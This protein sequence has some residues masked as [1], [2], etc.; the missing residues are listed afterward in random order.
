MKRRGGLADRQRRLRFRAAA[1]LALALACVALL[2]DRN[3][4]WLILAAAAGL[5]ALALVLRFPRM[6]GRQPDKRY[7]AFVAGRAAVLA[8]L[9]MLLGSLAVAHSGEKHARHI[10]LCEGQRVQLGDWELRLTRIVP[11]AGEGFTAIQADMAASRKAAPALTLS[12]RLLHRFASGPRGDGSSR[13]R[14][15][16]GDLALGLTG[17]GSAS[18][19]IALDAAWRPLAVW[20]VV[21][22]WL[23]ALG[24]LGMALMAW[25]SIAWRERA[26]GRIAMRREDQPLPGRPLAAAHAPPGRLLP[27][28]AIGLALVL[29]ALLAWP[30]TAAVPHPVYPGGAALIKARQSLIEGPPNTNRWIVIADA[31]ARRGRYADAAEILLGAVEASPQASEGWLALGDALYAHAGGVLTPA[32]ALAYER[33]DRAGLASFAARPLAAEAMERSAR[34]ALARAW[35][36]RGAPAILPGKQP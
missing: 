17:L 28:L 1:L 23:A 30:R 15:L 6:P 35:R 33:A 11:V 26:A 27:V 2:L 10:T 9:A 31:M 16:M 36:A 19:C 32:A 29:L 22:A 34:P 24:A 3:G 18:G 12:P 14:L 20:A 5:G 7:T 4:I 21:G 13:Q 25:C 8:G